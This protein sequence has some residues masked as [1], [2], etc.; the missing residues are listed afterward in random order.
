MSPIQV[1]EII[2]VLACIWQIFH[3]VEIISAQS[4]GKL[5]L[6]HIAGSF[7]NN[8]PENRLANPKVFLLIITFRIVISFAIIL[9]IIT[10]QFYWPA[11]ILLAFTSI[12]HANYRRVGGDGSEEIALIVI[13]STAL[14]TG[15]LYSNTSAL[16]AICFIG[17]QC[18]LSY[19]TAGIAKLSSR[20]W[21]SGEA[22]GLIIG[23]EAYGSPK[24]C[25]II[26][27]NPTLGSILTWSVILFEIVLPV[28]ILVWPYGVI[29]LIIL[30]LL[31]HVASAF[32]MGLNGF[33]LSFLSTYPAI[34][35]LSNYI[36]QTDL[37][38]S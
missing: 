31:F 28:S 10:N 11:L 4:S 3:S 16:I 27:Q 9:L 14:S 25:E 13:I 6:I 38:W 2:I 32:I 15:V 20:T 24:M 33:P 26:K 18:L 5:R 22:M 8:S 21:R 37:W 35:F 36:H 29:V 23:T 1:L 17:G 34:L 30:G 19:L 7:L 12:Y